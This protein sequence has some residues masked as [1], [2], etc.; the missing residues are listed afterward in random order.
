VKTVLFAWELGR[1]LGHLMNM[2]RLSARLKPHGFRF[3]AVARESAASD[4]LEGTFSE[5][6]AAPRWPIDSHP[7]SQRSALSSATLNDILSA[8]GLAD[9]GAVQHLIQAWDEIFKRTRPDLVIAD[10][11]PMAALAARGR[12]PLVH[13]GNGYTLPPHYMKRFPP[14][15][16]FSP[17][18]WNEEQTLAAVNQAAQ[19]CGR[20]PLDHLPQLFS[21]D[22][23][24]VQTFPLFDPY[25]TQR[26]E[27]LDGPIFDGAPAT[28]DADAQQIFAYL[29]SGYALHPSLFAALRPFA[30]RLR[31]QAP[32]MPLAQ[33][34]ALRHAGARIDT[35]PAPLAEIL[36]ATSLIVHNGGPGVAAEALVAG[37]P[38]LV[39]SA[40]VEQ[41]YNGHALKNAGAGEFLRIYEPGVEISAELIGAMATDEALAARAGQQAERHR[42][43]LATTDALGTY[44]R[45]CL[46][47]L[48]G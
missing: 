29:S 4:L 27:P 2:R 45:T 28:K 13:I 9:T 6:I 34:E 44:E 48:T 42:A 37:V 3:V 17:P 15:H 5:I 16:R 47:L 30:A 32:G 18:A 11:S 22:A 23:C 41:D 26:T 21:G 39:L 38:Q 7:A 12:L 36:P 20:V 31:L 35:Q 25:D 46:Q 43:Y 19:A 24:L 40:Q 10:F 33:V 1:G 8:M 14:L